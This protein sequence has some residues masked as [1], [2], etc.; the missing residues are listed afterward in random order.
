MTKTSCIY[1]NTNGITC[2]KNCYNDI[3]RSHRGRTLLKKCLV[4]DKYTAAKSGICRCNGHRK[5]FNHVVEERNEYILGW[6][7][8]KILNLP[9]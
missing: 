4:C 5:N 3:C 6:N 7:M 2:G 1:I 8:F 9:D